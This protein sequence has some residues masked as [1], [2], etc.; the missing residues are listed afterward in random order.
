MGKGGRTE[1]GEEYRMRRDVGH[2]KR[3]WKRYLSSQE[4][5][6][7]E[8]KRGTMEGEEMEREMRWVIRKIE[9]ELRDMRKKRRG[10]WDKECKAKK[11]KVKRKL[12][13]EERRRKEWNIGKKKRL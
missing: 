6:S 5:K 11:K 10:W 13:I 3:K 9:K 2:L 4:R 7:Q 12:R 1:L 8:Q